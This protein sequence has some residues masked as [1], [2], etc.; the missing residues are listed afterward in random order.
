MTSPPLTQEGDD[1]E[2]RGSQVKSSEVR[3]Q[4]NE[5]SVSVIY[6]HS[7]VMR[8]TEDCLDLIS[9]NRETDDG[10]D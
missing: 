4:I 1:S 10:H 5:L 6:T 8:A 2:R 7:E 9:S 3:K